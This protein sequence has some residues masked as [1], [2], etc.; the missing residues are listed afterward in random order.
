V[1]SVGGSQRQEEGERKRGGE[2]CEQLAVTTHLCIHR[3]AFLFVLFVFLDE[4]REAL[5]KTFISKSESRG[6]T[7]KKM[8]ATAD[9][10]KSASPT[11]VLM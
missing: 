3:S 11:G 5:W 10:T 6:G 7:P 8:Q 4:K 1:V 9:K 2:R